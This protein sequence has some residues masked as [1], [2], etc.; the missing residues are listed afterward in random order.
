MNVHGLLCRQ[1]EPAAGFAYVLN[2]TT[3]LCFRPAQ[4]DSRSL[5]G[6]SAATVT[7]TKRR[8]FQTRH[9]NTRYQQENPIPGQDNKRF[10]RKK[11]QETQKKV[12]LRFL[13]LFAAKGL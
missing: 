11:A 3:A 10:C 4:A 5:P 2:N 7:T 6:K 9:E 13:C 1:R 12:S 8:L